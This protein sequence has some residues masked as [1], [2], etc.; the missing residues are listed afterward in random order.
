MTHLH[1]CPP[2]KSIHPLEVIDQLDAGYILDIVRR[3]RNFFVWQL[4]Q[5]S[6][7]GLLS[8]VA[9]HFPELRISGCGSKL[10]PSYEALIWRLQIRGDL[11]CDK[12]G[13]RLTDKGERRCNS[14]FKAALVAPLW[15]E[16]VEQIKEDLMIFSETEGVL[17]AVA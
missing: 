15:V 14:A 6:L 3:F 10:H 2:S 4:D 11:A 13:F 9:R 5:E 8:L 12:E 16:A 17:L 1:L 7:C